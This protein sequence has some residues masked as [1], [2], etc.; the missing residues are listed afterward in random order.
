MCVLGVASRGGS[1]QGFGVAMTNGLTLTQL[2]DAVAI[3][4][5]VA[6]E[7]LKL[8]ALKTDCEGCEWTLLPTLRE[9]LM[10][11]VHLPGTKMRFWRW[12]SL[13]RRPSA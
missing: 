3:H 7:L 12:P 8:R 1:T 11:P 9:W 13:L 5:T 6:E 2:Q 10:P 4:P